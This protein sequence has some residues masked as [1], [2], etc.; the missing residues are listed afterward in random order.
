MSEC[1][2]R[3]WWKACVPVSFHVSC[4]ACYGALAKRS[5]GFHIARDA[6][7]CWR[8][9]EQWHPVENCGRYELGCVPE[10][11]DQHGGALLQLVTVNGLA[12]IDMKNH[13]VKPK[14][15]PAPCPEC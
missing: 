13:I 14:Y 2:L 11:S 8:K 12:E 15:H 1:S 10:E 4:E 7:R 6:C 3:S 5:S 9:R